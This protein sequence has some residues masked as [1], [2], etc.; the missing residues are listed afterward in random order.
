M[1]LKVGRRKPSEHKTCKI[2]YSVMLEDE[3][4]VNIKLVRLGSEDGNL[5]NI[6]LVRSG[7]V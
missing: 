4:L 3:N 7:I 5:V 2:K 1:A 6:K